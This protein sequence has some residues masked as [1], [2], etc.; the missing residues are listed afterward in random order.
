MNYSGEVKNGVVVFQDA[1]RPADGTIVR[2]EPLTGVQ[3]IPHPGSREAV[4]KCDTRWYGDPA[5]VD[6]LLIE[7]QR[8][9]DADLTQF[10]TPK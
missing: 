9:R 7:V 4:Q 6:Q 5:E 8:A 1:Q 3:K 2:V 10:E